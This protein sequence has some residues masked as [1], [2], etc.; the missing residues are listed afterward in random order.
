MISQKM[1]SQNI[2]KTWAFATAVNRTLS[3][4]GEEPVN[5]QETNGLTTCRT[6]SLEPSLLKCCNMVCVLCNGRDSMVVDDGLVPVRRQDISNNHDDIGRPIIE[7]TLP[8]DAIYIYTSITILVPMEFPCIDFTLSVWIIYMDVLRY[9]F[10][11]DNYNMEITSEHIE[12]V[13]TQW[14]IYI[15]IYIYIYKYLISFMGW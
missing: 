2:R 12:S 5:D 9:C 6:A 15:Y 14:Y 13:V 7:F 1:I 8:N 10:S 4:W 3:L 11:Y